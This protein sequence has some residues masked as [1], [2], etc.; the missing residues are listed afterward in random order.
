VNVCGEVTSVRRERSTR[1]GRHGYFYVTI[2]GYPNPR[3]IE[4]VSNL[5]A[6]GSASSGEPPAWPWVA[7]GDY[8]YV[9]GR[10]YYDSPRRSGIDW[11]E[12]ET[13]ASWPHNGYVAVCNASGQGCT[14]FR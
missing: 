1:S 13:S 3:G 9:Q 7:P 14:L 6:M 12:A 11:T 4:I 10:Y 5:D 2:P 8:V